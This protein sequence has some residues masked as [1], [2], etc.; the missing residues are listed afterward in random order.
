M[1][2]SIII[3]VFNV[4]RYIIR[5][6]DSLYNQELSEDDY[7]VIIINDGSN[8][9][10]LLLAEKFKV[11]HKN[12]HIYIQE[13][14]GVGAARNKGISLAKGAY[15]Y[16]IDPDDYLVA[17]VLN[18]L[19]GCLNAQSPDVLTFISKSATVSSAVSEERS[20]IAKPMSIST[21]TGINYI[22]NNNYKNEVWWY[23][24]KKSFL[25]T[26][27]LKF[28]E[29][30]WM[31]D[32][33]FTASL[34]IQAKSVIAVPI[35][36]HRHVKVQGSVMTNKEP[37][38]YLKVINDNA[39]IAIVFNSIINELKANTD[40]N[41]R[42]IKRLKSRQQSFVFFMLLR[43]M[44]STI[45]KAEILPLLKKMKQ[46]KAYPLNYFLGEDYNGW[47]YTIL[48]KSFSNRYIFYFIFLVMNPMLKERT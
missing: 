5:C 22:A 29:G 13:N 2:L 23:F 33:I 1:K 11:N 10:S 45:N 17:G 28:I 27:N 6:L 31:E 7:E 20:S 41:D 35:D 15:I 18:R 36:A 16:F 3:P 38:H 47:M 8:D 25:D 30:K 32:A 42:C 44:K 14:Q 9:N 37:N 46:E 26:I 24:I 40:A 19:I 4:E 12:L 34:L 21:D 48:S 39:N 43:I